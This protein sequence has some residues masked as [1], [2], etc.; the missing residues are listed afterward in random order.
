MSIC[1]GVG[2]A[3][4]RS[5]G[6]L[7]LDISLFLLIKKA[8]YALVDPVEAKGLGNFKNILTKGSCSIKPGSYTQFSYHRPYYFN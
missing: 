2:T 4:F 3:V 5:F 8:K 1:L 6:L 7:L